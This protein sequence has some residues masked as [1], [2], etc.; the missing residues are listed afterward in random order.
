MK[1]RKQFDSHEEIERIMRYISTNRKFSQAMLKEDLDNL[2]Y[3]GITEGTEI[4][5]K[6]EID[7]ANKKRQ[8]DP[9]KQNFPFKFKIGDLVQLKS[10]GPIMVVEFMEKDKK[11]EQNTY[12]CRYFNEKQGDTNTEWFFED[13]LT[14]RR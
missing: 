13:I 9:S 5:K 12:T 7:I 11:T 10:G 8:V 6:V 3:Q 4:S 1:E 2:Y 14:E